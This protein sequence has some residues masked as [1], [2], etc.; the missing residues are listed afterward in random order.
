GGAQ[1]AAPIT[2]PATTTPAAATDIRARPRRRATDGIRLM[3]TTI[4]PRPDFYRRWPKL[5]TVG[6]AADVAGRGANAV[7]LS[8]CLKESHVA[9]VIGGTKS[10]IGR[11]W[12]RARV[13]RA[14]E[15]G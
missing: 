12:P 5:S 9:G 13:A 10:R 7:A 1:A 15:S 6:R 4:G 14:L 2:R 8:V 11:G 3:L